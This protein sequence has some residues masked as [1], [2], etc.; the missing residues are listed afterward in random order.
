MPQSEDFYQYAM[1][2]SDRIKAIQDISLLAYEAVGGMGYTRADIR[3]DAATEQLYVLEVNAQ[4]GLSEDE[5]YTSIGAIL[6]VN[7][8]SFAQLIWEVLQ[9]ALQRSNYPDYT[10]TIQ[11]SS[12]VR[13]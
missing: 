7:Q 2:P 9:D 3:M 12:E 1:P 11:K 10:Y 13:L 4:C 5:N 6:R 8:T